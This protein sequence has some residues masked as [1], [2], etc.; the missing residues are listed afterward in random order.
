MWNFWDAE[1][2]DLCC[3]SES[4]DSFGDCDSENS[5]NGPAKDAVFEFAEDEAAFIN[6]YVR[7]WNIA[8]ENGFTGMTAIGDGNGLATF[9]NAHL[10]AKVTQS[11]EY[12]FWACEAT[13]F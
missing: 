13:L 2:R 9:D 4:P 8:T 11:C 6:G 12:S 5:P 10:A 7:A 3:A 1:N